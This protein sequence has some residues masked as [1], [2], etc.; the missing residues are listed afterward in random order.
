MQSALSFFPP[1]RQPRPRQVRALEFMEQSIKDGFKD[2]V[3]EMPTG[4]GKSYCGATAAFYATALSQLSGANGGWLLVNQ[5]LLQ[6]QLQRDVPYMENGDKTVGQVKNSG[7]YTCNIHG[8]CDVGLVKRCPNTRKDDCDCP[9]KK[10]KAKTVAATLGITNYAYFFTERSSDKSQMAKRR[11]LICDE[12]H[13]LARL[14]TRFVDVSIS[15]AVLDKW[16]P[17]LAMT[18]DPRDFKDIHQ[19]NT[20]L[21]DVYVPELEERAKDFAAVADGD[22][23]LLK[24]AFEFANHACKVVTMTV[25]NN[26]PR[27]H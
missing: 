7:E 22:D 18:T 17:M 2:I 26:S 25:P 5:K 19:F 6:D 11:I 24:E 1:S 13:N 12:A 14:V 3:L 20:W 15:R 27:T 9:Y 8:T 21:Q 4:S 23:K 10:A 16:T